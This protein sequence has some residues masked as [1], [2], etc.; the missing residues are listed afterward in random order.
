MTSNL[1]TRIEQ[2]GQDLLIVL[3]SCEPAPR[4]IW[5]GKRYAGFLFLRWSSFGFGVEILSAGFGVQIGPVMIGVCHIQHQL[6]EGT[7]P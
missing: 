7:E 3:P 6:A 2:A 1:S 5:R 4:K